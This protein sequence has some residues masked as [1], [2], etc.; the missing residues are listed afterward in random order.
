[1]PLN[2]ELLGKI[3][4]STKPLVVE[5][6]RIAAYAD[7]T[8]TQNP[9]YV[10]T[11]SP[12]GGVAPPIYGVVASFETL[13]ETILDPELGITLPRLLHS[14]QIMRFLQLLRVGDAVTS[15]ARIAAFWDRR[16]GEQVDLDVALKRG[17]SVLYQA[18][19][20][21][22]VRADT[23]EEAARRR[24]DHPTTPPRPALP[25]PA[26]GAP[27]LLETTVEVAPDQSLR[28]A[29]AS[30]DHNPL[31]KDDAFA[32]AAGLPGRILHGLCTMAMA[33]HAIVD[34]VAGG[35]PGRL[36]SQRGRFTRPVFMG[37]RLT[38]RGAL[39]E[40][41]G[42]RITLGYEVLNQEGK[43]VIK[44]GVAEVAS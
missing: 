9:A 7:A 43:P 13:V 6:E 11:A 4:R 1:M 30:G 42:D 21:L 41:A 32:R 17:D 24:R 23:E 2:R 22:F 36:L 20:G 16:G 34:A 35:D 40:R 18:T 25:R 29:E 26:R 12:G 28:Y 37:D 8:N 27:L 33:Q 3:Y 15:E 31:H 10:D 19:I 39:I 5:A 38:T 14:E 44:E